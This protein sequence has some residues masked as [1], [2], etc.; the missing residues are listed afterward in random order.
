MLSAFLIRCG[1]IHLQLRIIKVLKFNISITA[2][3]WEILNSY[4]SRTSWS[5]TSEYMLIFFSHQKL[6]VAKGFGQSFWSK[7]WNFFYSWHI[8]CSER[9]S[10]EL[11]AFSE[12]NL[13]PFC[14]LTSHT[15]ASSFQPL[16]YTS[17]NRHEWLT[18]IWMTSVG[19]HQDTERQL[20]LPGQHRSW[21][22]RGS[23]TPSTKIWIDEYSNAWK[24]HSSAIISFSPGPTSPSKRRYGVIFWLNV[25]QFFLKNNFY[26]A[27]RNKCVVS[28]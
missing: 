11:I 19:M 12:T 16:R 25:V 7:P 5:N 9:A 8:Y 22:S 15:A 14:D 17:M 6:D 26:I 24:Q 13:C 20:F 3:F 4:Y 1:I 23:G 27:C 18:N 28:H 10:S 21:S 2:I